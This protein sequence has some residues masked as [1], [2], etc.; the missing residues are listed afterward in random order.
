MSSKPRG[1]VLPREFYARPAL[2]VAKELI[3][4][5]LVRRIDGRMVD[6]TI[7][8]TEAYIGPKD[9]DPQQNSWVEWIG[10]EAA[11]VSPSVASFGFV[12]SGVRATRGLI[13]AP[14]AP[15]SLSLCSVQVV[16]AVGVRGLVLSSQSTSSLSIELRMTSSFRIQA[17]I[18]TFFGLPA[19]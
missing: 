8:E 7:T 14:S 12:T 16:Q 1:I 11:A 5:T 13:A 18:A 9:K 6:E 17:T 2:V 10:F 4:K 19:A 3:G 15:A